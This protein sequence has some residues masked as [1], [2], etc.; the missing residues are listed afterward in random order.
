MAKRKTIG[1]NSPLELLGGD[2]LDFIGSSAGDGPAERAGPSAGPA[3]VEAPPPEKKAT[4]QLPVG[5]IEDVRDAAY[6]DRRTVNETAAVLL[7]RGLEALAA[8]RG[9]PY[10]PRPDR[11]D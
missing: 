3:D 7:R 8:E 1:E 5:L 11:A 2:P 9:A 4:Y 6:W 10:E